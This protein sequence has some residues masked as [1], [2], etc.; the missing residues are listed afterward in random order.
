MKIL[1]WL[2]LL[3][4]TA[5]VSFAQDDNITPPDP[6]APGGWQNNGLNGPTFTTNVTTSGGSSSGIHPLGQTGDPALAEAITPEIQA[7]ARGLENDPLRIFNYVHDHIRHSFYFGSVKGAQLTLS[8]QCGNDFD[9][10]AL[11]VALLRAAGYSPS[12]G[13][14]L[15]QMPFSQA[16]NQDLQHWLGLNVTNTDWPTKFNYLSALLQKSGFTTNDIFD[17]GDNN[18]IAFHRLWV[19]VSTNGVTYNLDPAF[20]ISTPIVGINLPAA[21]SFNTNDLINAAGGQ[22]TADYATNLN[23]GNLRNK[24]RDYTTNLLYTLQNNY[25]NYSVDQ[26]L[27]GRQIQPWTNALPQSLLFSIYTA[28]GTIQTQSWDNI[29]APY[30]ATLNLNIGGVISYTWNTA[31]LRGQRI[32]LT[33]DS[34][35]VGTLWQDDIA[36]ATAGFGVTTITVSDLFIFPSASWDTTLNSITLGYGFS[37]SGS[38]YTGNSTYAIVYGFDTSAKVLR[39]RQDVL[40]TYLQEGYTNGTRPVLCESLNVM[41][42]NWL[43]QTALA[44]RLLA[45]QSGLIQRNYDRIGCMGQVSGQGYYIDVYG[46]DPADFPNDGIGATQMARS[47]QDTDTLVYFASAMEH[48]V[49]EQQSSNLVAAS[50]VKMLQTGNANH[51]ATFLATSSNWSSVKG[52]LTNWDTNGLTG[53][54]NQGYTLLLTKDGKQYVSGTSGWQGYGFQARQATFTTNGTVATLDLLMKIKGNY[55]GGFAGTPSAV[56]NT[57]TIWTDI[58][59]QSTAF[60]PVSPF[61]QSTFA[62]DPVSMA[63]ASFR[64]NTTDLSL[65]Q[66][67]PLGLNFSRSYSPARRHHNL[68]SMANGWVNSYYFNLSEVSDPEP[69]LGSTT[70]AQMAPLLVA[71]CAALNFYKPQPNPQNWLITALISKWA[72]DQI[73]SNAV[74]I[75]LGSDTLEFVREPDGSFAP[76]ANCTYSLT[77]GSTYA[78]QERHG[79]TFNFSTS[80]QLNT[81]TNPSG[82]TLNLTYTSG[83][84]TQAADW[85]GRTLAFTY[86]GTPSRITKV[87]DNAG[88][89]VTYG[90]LT[91]TDGN[92]DMVY[93][94]D[95]DSNTNW[96]TYD[97][98]HQI[99]ATADALG[100]L[101]VTNIYDGFGHVTTQYTQGNINK[102]WQIFWTGWETVSQDPAGGRHCYFYDDKSRQTGE[103]DELGNLSQKFYDGQDHVVLNV[104]PLN[105]VSQFVY[106]GSNNL[107]QSIDPLG[108]TNQLFYDGQNNLVRSLDP[109][110]NASTFGYDGQ[111]RLT[112][113]TN[114]ANDWVNY[115]Y[116]SDGTLHTRADTGG[117]ATYTFDIFGQLSTTTYSGIAGVDTYYNNSLGDV[118]NHV[119]GRGIA[120]SFQ[121]NNRRQMTK[122]IATN[123]VTKIALD[124]VG[125]VTLTTDPRGNSVSNSWS[126]TRHLL[127][128]TYPATPQGTAMVTNAYDGR[129]WLVCS[130]GPLQNPTIYTNDAAGRLF[131]LTDPVQRT[132][133]F[134]YDADGRQTATTNAAKEVTSQVFDARGSLLKLTD[135][136]GHFSLRGYDAGGNQI[137]LTNRN[138]NGWQFY[139]DQAN[140]LTNTV[141]PKGRSTTLA[142]NHQGKVATI[143][144][145]AN[146]LTSLFYDAKGRLTNRADI[147]ATNFY[148]Y[149]GSDNLT[150]VTENS[151]SNSWT[152]DAHNQVATYRDTAGYLIQYLYDANGNLTN[153]IY[154]GTNNVYYAYDTMNRLT[155]VVDWTGRRSTISYDLAGHVTCLMRPNGSF[156]TNNYD[157]A[158]QVTSIYEQMSN[159][160][161]IAYFKYNW[162]NSGSMAWEF[163]APLRNKSA[164][165]TRTMT[166]DADNRLS[167]VNGTSVTN[168]LDGNLTFAPLTNGV[169]TNLIYDA[170]NRLL[171]AGGVTNIYD[172]A[173]NRIGQNYGTNTAT[174]V[175]NPNA[176]LPQVLMRIKNGVT[177]YYIYGAGLM[178]QISVAGTNTTTLT[179]HYDYR[180]STVALSADNGTIT[181]RIEYSGYG[182]TTYRV[183]TNDTPFLFN[184]RYGVQSD[185]SGLLYMRARY[186]NPY[187]CRFI[188]SDPSGFAGGLNH[189]AYANG[190][191]VSYLDPFGLGAVGENSSSSWIMN[192]IAGTASD[193]GNSLV[194]SAYGAANLVNGAVMQIGNAALTGLGM[195]G[196][197]QQTALGA[198]GIDDP[199]MLG[200]AGGVL[201]EEMAA[202]K[203]LGG[204]AQSA[205]ATIAAEGTMAVSP[206]RMTTGG[207][208]FFHYGYADSAAS[209]EGGLRPGGFATSIGDLSG[210]EAQSGLALPRPTAPPNAVYTVTPQSGTWI[211][212]NPVAEPL[213]G[214]PGGLP[215]FQFPGGTGPG[216]VS[217]PTL[218]PPR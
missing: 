146:Q 21:I 178:Y 92:L 56:V 213:F 29:A 4:L 7:L 159:S 202:L 39:Q 138:M 58:A 174:F 109:L 206:Y 150:S 164:V 71:T 118:T 130:V 97:T 10:C 157:A 89:F 160:L 210:A 189:Y 49:I 54:I 199:M 208:T 175:V 24:L 139:F 117:T 121:Y 156:R 8:E 33:F 112:G 212:V 32:S 144:D 26:I 125:N 151:K 142:F 11:L 2:C 191:P 185:A 143:K 162:T 211:R 87:T 195:A 91:N 148:N 182:L 166:Y 14:G 204:L 20:K 110:G 79:N 25:P 81:I 196:A 193:I 141:T 123:A 114:G 102:T 179:Y 149:D 60:T 84:L 3:A 136:A 44:D 38:Y 40:N 197:A 69:S 37:H 78:L 83:Q 215:E 155:S 52:K 111:F 15:L 115:T 134:A 76:P 205:E 153:L 167:S 85:K 190:N 187:L 129:D 23:E 119:D 74:S 18:T 46:N 72:V 75:S 152:F 107:V 5:T 154:P 36:L 203:G 12:Y 100:R 13:F 172:A 184:G 105:E 42:M 192:G 27:G 218:I 201:T 131:S 73:T 63:D 34:N 43:L 65:G 124:G 95:P 98:N 216:T 128:T 137:I 127:T 19:V 209:F 62:G 22:S 104:S 158:G 169:F 101:V 93:A 94:S 28:G 170:R 17:M 55:N 30:L 47:F 171:N 161:P 51:L 31:E 132:T 1:Q 80:K 140:R 126:A 61:V 145:P 133:T 113:S 116:N 53:Y 70:P 176:K 35:G 122:A 108:F 147:L 41:G 186:Y 103:Q 135:G 9:Q 64:V 183:G 16:N 66:R 90:Y 181:D 194:N 86:S 207:E 45:Q 67:E 120:T 57:P 200:V 168:D 163:A 59:A 106:D 173:N 177:N 96:F 82:A 6:N 180:G 88:R 68:A 77:K 217:G 50:T 48:G 99:V 188:S 198:V 214:Q 165:P